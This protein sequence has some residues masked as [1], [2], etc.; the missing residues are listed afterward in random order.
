MLLPELLLYVLGIRSAALLDLAVE[1][2]RGSSWKTC[3]PIVSVWE[4][5]M[6]HMSLAHP[7]FQEH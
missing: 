1:E 2:E 7:A 3:L 6:F 5:L 4:S